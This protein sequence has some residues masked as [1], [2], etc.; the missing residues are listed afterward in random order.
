VLI[1]LFVVLAVDAFSARPDRTTLTLAG[2][3]AAVALLIA[4]GSMLLVAVSIFTAALS[5]GVTTP[6]SASSPAPEPASP[7][8]LVHAG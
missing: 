6:S 8:Q 4:P 2:G 3:S 1:A 7:C 5:C